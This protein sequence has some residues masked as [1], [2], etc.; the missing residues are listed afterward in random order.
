MLQEEGRSDHRQ[1]HQ[2]N[3]HE[4]VGGAPGRLQTE[5]QNSHFF[6]DFSVQRLHAVLRSLL[7]SASGGC[8]CTVL[9]HS[10]VLTAGFS[11]S[12]QF[13]TIPCSVGYFYVKTP[14]LFFKSQ[15]FMQ[16][17][18]FWVQFWFESDGSRFD[19]IL[20][21]AGQSEKSVSILF[22]FE[23]QKSI[24]DRF[25]WRMCITKAFLHRTFVDHFL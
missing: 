22:C 7:A 23:M 25:C 17:S 6:T 19:C 5:I 10:F 18:F 21:S 24:C 1:A 11:M 14:R 16:V 20:V 2:T 9:A 4:T 12:S 3:K 15:L 8:G 13:V